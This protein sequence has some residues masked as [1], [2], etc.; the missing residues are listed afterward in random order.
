MSV[1]DERFC[2]ARARVRFL[3]G[4]PNSHFGLEAN[5][6][7]DATIPIQTTSPISKAQLSAEQIDFLGR[8]DLSKGH[9]ALL[10]IQTNADDAIARQLLKLGM[11]AYINAGYIFAQLTSRS[12]GHTSELQSIMRI[13]YA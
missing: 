9:D 2:T 13:S 4:A 12:E 11:I 6:M 7:T 3:A 1:V 10:Q 5:S 8:F